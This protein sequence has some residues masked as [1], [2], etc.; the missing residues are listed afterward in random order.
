[1][2]QSVFIHYYNE[3]EGKAGT[4][5]VDALI[6]ATGYQKKSNIPLLKHLEEYLVT[7]KTTGLYEVDLNNRIKATPNLEAQIYLQNDLIPSRSASE[8]TISTVAQRSNRLMASIARHL[9]N[10]YL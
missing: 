6:L 9:E 10:T 8:N 2:N 3:I 4:E 7:N 1:M 5:L